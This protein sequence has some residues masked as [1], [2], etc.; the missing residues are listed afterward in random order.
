MEVMAKMAR[1][2]VARRRGGADPP[3]RA[4][5]GCC[6]GLPPPPDR[7]TARE[8]EELLQDTLLPVVPGHE[9]RGRRCWGRRARAH[10]SSRVW[11]CFDQM[12][13]VPRPSGGLGKYPAVAG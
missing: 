11:S 9:D 8:A 12:L 7:G 3:V 2:A 1:P 4:P 13:P 6:R 10:R 5:G